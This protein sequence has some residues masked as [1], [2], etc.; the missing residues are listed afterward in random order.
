MY[1]TFGAENG[2][3][4]TGSSFSFA[5]E[6]I[7]F[8][9]PDRFN[10]SGDSHPQFGFL[11]EYA[12]G[13]DVLTA[14]MSNDHPTIFKTALSTAGSTQ[15]PEESPVVSLSEYILKKK[16]RKDFPTNSV[17]ESTSVLNMFPEFTTLH[18]EPAAQ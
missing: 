8:N 13:Y 18:Y 10:Y 15:I 14:K 11:P 9:L 17:I 12:M 3:D 16:K 5:L 4:V 7:L 2:I 1:I 6:A